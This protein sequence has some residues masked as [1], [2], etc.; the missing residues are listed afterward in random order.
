MPTTPD[1][2]AQHHAEMLFSYQDDLTLFTKYQTLLM[3]AL[4]DPLLD[5]KPTRPV[6]LQLGLTYL[7]SHEDLLESKQ[8]L[9]HEYEYGIGI[10]LKKD[11]LEPL[12]LWITD[13]GLYAEIFKTTSSLSKLGLETNIDILLTALQTKKALHPAFVTL[14]DYAYHLLQEMRLCQQ[15]AWITH[16]WL[17]RGIERDVMYRASISKEKLPEGTEKSFLHLTSE[18]EQTL[19]AID[20]FILL[21]AYRATHVLIESKEQLLTKPLIPDWWSK[22]AFS[23]EL[24]QTI[25]LLLTFLLQAKLQTVKPYKF[26]YQQL[27]AAVWQKENKASQ[28]N[29]QALTHHFY[30]TL[31]EKIQAAPDQKKLLQVIGTISL[32]DGTRYW[33]E[34]QEAMWQQKLVTD[35]LV[36]EDK[37][38]DLDK[39]ISRYTGLKLPLLWV[40]RSDNYHYLFKI[41]VAAELITSTGELKERT[42][43]LKGRRRVRNFPAIHPQYYFKILPEMPGIEYS[44]HDLSQRLMAKGT[45]NT[46]YHVLIV[47]EK[48]Q[49]PHPKHERPYPI[50]ISEAIRQAP[51]LKGQQLEEALLADAKGVQTKISSYSFTQWV[52][53]SWFCQN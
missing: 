6:F 44:I 38:L 36:P 5:S 10:D 1:A 31:K 2:Y 53:L 28:Q 3:D 23:Q 17:G 27:I 41:Q 16:R 13:L 42:E 24:T 30:H 50:L 33:Q 11:Y 46:A 52:L 49:S 48:D 29:C 40:K 20:Q 18:Q 43:G 8:R 7:K 14:L 22:E 26:A 51:D 12:V 19:A 45:A 47:T 21:P 34:E 25:D 35:L 37:K 15:E 39:E 9:Q 32:P 4:T